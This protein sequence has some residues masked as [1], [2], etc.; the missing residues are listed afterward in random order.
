MSA[1][2]YRHGIST[3]ANDINNAPTLSAS[4]RVTQDHHRRLDEYAKAQDK[5]KNN[6]PIQENNEI[7]SD[8][9][10]IVGDIRAQVEGPSPWDEER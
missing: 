8:W 2:Q 10:G 4:I 7:I 9:D 3:Y 6:T 5:F 1:N